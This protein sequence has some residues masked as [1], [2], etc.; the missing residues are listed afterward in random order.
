MHF[1]IGNHD[2]IDENLAKRFDS[3]SK[4]KEISITG[5]KITLCHYAMRAW[6]CSA[7]GAWQLFGHS[8]GNL[9]AVGKQI[10]VGVDTNNFMPYSYEKICEIMKTREKNEDE[11][12]KN[13]ET[14]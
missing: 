8:H 1:I 3:V 5:Q 6:N 7:H 12:T 4:V 14:I 10:D 11:R 9:V 2:R 13:L